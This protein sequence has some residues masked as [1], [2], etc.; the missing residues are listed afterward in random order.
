ML[1]P[2]AKPCVVGKTQSNDTDTE[3]FARHINIPWLL[4]VNTVMSVLLTL[5]R[6]NQSSGKFFTSYRISSKVE[7]SMPR[8]ATL[9]AVMGFPLPTAISP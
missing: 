4:N 1:I 5:N 3:Y 7:M 8:L 6:L 9:V 2:V